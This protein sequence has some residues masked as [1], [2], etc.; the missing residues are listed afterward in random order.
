[1]AKGK[2]AVSAAIISAVSVIH[3]SASR[4]VRPSG[5]ESQD[6]VKFEQVAER[7]IDLTFR[8]TLRDGQ[9]VNPVE[10]MEYIKAFGASK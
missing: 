8:I 5:E 4:H 1:M 3:S 6:S 9:S 2:R 7:V 10:L